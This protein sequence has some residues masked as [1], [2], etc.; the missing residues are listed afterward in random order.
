MANSGG[1]GGILDPNQAGELAKPGSGGTDVFGHTEDKMSRYANARNNQRTHNLIRSQIYAA[2]H[3]GTPCWIYN[4]S[5]IFQ[6]KR[7]YKGLGE[8]LIP[9]APSV[10]DPIVKNGK[11]VDATAEDIKGAFRLSAPVEIS[12]SYIESYDKGDNRRVPYVTEGQEIAESIVGNSKMYPVGLNDQTANLE[13][14]GVFITYGVP[15]EELPEAEQHKLLVQAEAFHRKRLVEKMLSGDR[16]YDRAKITG[17]GGPLEIHRLAVAELGETRTWTHDRA[18]KAPTGSTIECPFCT[19][20]I[21]ATAIV[22]SSCKNIVD[23]VK[24][25]AKKKALKSQDGVED[26]E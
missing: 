12:H 8:F 16:L 23:P 19:T 15:F 24:Y 9:K 20:D 2:E 17:R 11:Q 14:W 21:K 6:W 13:S 5:R 26:A 7:T 22:C 1:R 25:A 10:G 3:A 18:L 4:I